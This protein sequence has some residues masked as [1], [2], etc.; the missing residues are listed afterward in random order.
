MIHGGNLEPVNR[1]T[2]ANAQRVQLI[3]H[4]L[5]DRFTAEPEERQQQPSSVPVLE[6]TSIA[7]HE[8]ILR[9]AELF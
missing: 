7:Q 9:A 5:S 1:R 2:A 4:A 3:I 8:F 6:R